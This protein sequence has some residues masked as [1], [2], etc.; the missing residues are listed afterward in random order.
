M[1]SYLGANITLDFTPYTEVVDASVI[2]QWI[3]VD[4]NM[5]VTFNQD[6]VRGYIAGLAEK[7][8]TYGRPRTFTTGFG[9]SVQVEG[10]SYGWLIDQE[11]EYNALTAN[12]QNAETVTRE[13][14]YA[15][16]AASGQ[17]ASR[18]DL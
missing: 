8:D 12:I 16:R 9:N 15:R 1:N 5:Q 3:N 2:A 18:R 14:N 13:P 10:G 6:A 4:E 17:E 7:Y 11:A